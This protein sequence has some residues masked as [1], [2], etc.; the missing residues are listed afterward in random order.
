MKLEVL[1]KRIMLEE[2]GK[3]NKEFNTNSNKDLEEH[4]E[5]ANSNTK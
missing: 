1:K 5:Y 3:R 4:F 2:Q